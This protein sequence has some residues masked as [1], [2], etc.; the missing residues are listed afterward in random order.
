MKPV[1]TWVLIA[2]GARALVFRHD[3]PDNGLAIV[4]DMQFSE[5]PLM[6]RD[7]MADKQ[8]RSFASAGHGRSAMEIPTDPVDKRE[9][10]FVRKVI[11]KLA[12][13]HQDGAF[14]KLVIAAAPQAL[15]DIRKIMPQQL[16]EAVVHEMP[17]DLTR[18]PTADLPRHFEGVLKF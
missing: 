11:E 17:K 15:G 7:I 16:R 1:V 13:K 8:G 2:D 10:D 4:P 12:K 9:A 5:E 14:R 3:G 18:I 6:A